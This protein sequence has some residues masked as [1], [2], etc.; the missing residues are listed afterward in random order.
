MADPEPITA[1]SRYQVTAAV[2]AGDSDSFTVPAR[3]SALSSTICV[4][5]MAVT[6]TTETPLPDLPSL[7]VKV[8]A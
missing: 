1:R 4:V 8:S 6:L 7:T 2:T 3:G 5:A